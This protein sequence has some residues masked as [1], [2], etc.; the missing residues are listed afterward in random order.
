M[1]VCGFLTKLFS[2]PFFEL[3]RSLCLGYLMYQQVLSGGVLVGGGGVMTHVD[4]WTHS[5]CLI[6][7]LAHPWAIRGK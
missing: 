7:I 6:S 4:P 1:Q 5:T 3:A 2:S